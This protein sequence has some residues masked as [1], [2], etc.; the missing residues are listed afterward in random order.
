MCRYKQ[1]I[2]TYAHTCWSALTNRH[3]GMRYCLPMRMHVHSHK[4]HRH[5]VCR[6]SSHQLLPDENHNCYVYMRS[7]CAGVMSHLGS[8]I[9]RGGYRCTVDP[10]K[11]L[12][13]H[14]HACTLASATRACTRFSLPPVLRVCSL[15]LLKTLP[16]RSLQVSVYMGVTHP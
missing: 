11:S 8:S 5:L 1:G 6:E 16:N 10:T 13:P 7:T 12:L 2:T 15:Q 3:H 9:F 14:V 4:T